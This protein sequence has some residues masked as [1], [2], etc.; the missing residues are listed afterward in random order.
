M[1]GPTR[2]LHPY[3]CFSDYDLYKIP[4]PGILKSDDD[5]DDDDFDHGDPMGPQRTYGANGALQ[6][7]MGLYRNHGP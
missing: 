6:D 2:A 1:Q 3:V 7:P 5:D 4:A